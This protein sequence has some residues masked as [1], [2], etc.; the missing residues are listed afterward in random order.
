MLHRIK[1]WQETLIRGPA[2]NGLLTQFCW[3]AVSLKQFM[4]STINIMEIFKPLPPLPTSLKKIVNKDIYLTSR[5][6]DQKLIQQVNKTS[7]PLTRIRK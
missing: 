3:L 4:S 7:G 1:S 6:G 2:K 5:S